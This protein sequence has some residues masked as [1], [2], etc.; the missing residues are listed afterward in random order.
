MRINKKITAALAAIALVFNCGIGCFIPQKTARAEEAQVITAQDVEE[1]Q[2]FGRA[3]FM[4]NNVSAK[5]Y[6]SLWFDKLYPENVTDRNSGREVRYTDDL[7]VLMQFTMHFGS[8]AYVR[9][10]VLGGDSLPDNSGAFKFASGSTVLFSARAGLTFSGGPMNFDPGV[11]LKV[12]DIS[13]P[14]IVW[15]ISS[16]ESNIY[17][18]G[19]EYYGDILDRIKKRTTGMTK[20]GSTAFIADNITQGQK[21]SDA[22]INTSNI[23]W[24]ASVPGTWE[25]VDG[26][27]VPEVG[28][29]K[30]DVR[31]VPENELAYETLTFTETGEITV[32]EAPA[33]GGENGGNQSGGE[34]GQNAGQTGE[35]QSGGNQSG[36]NNSG[37]ESQSGGNQPGNENQSGGTNTGG[38]TSPGNNGGNNPSASET[39]P[40]SETTPETPPDDPAVTGAAVSVVEDDGEEEEEIIQPIIIE[41]VVD[42]ITKVKT[43]TVA[44]TKITKAKRTGTKLTIKVKKI[45]GAKYQLQYTTKPK[46]WKKAKS[47]KFSSTKK[48][49]K[50]L[51]KNKKYYIRIRAY[52]K[53]KGKTVYGSWCKR[54]S[55]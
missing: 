5:Y 9:I 2:N 51:T 38:N 49:I 24:E 28:T 27:T 41:K 22:R 52:K 1:M 25:F 55:C 10:N 11:K 15:D 12:V 8:K 26:D 17:G 43:N 18:N 48:T 20:S 35:N 54:R 19:V 14:G 44:T 21:L 32:D 39:N 45:K 4:Q 23:Y 50:G 3:N 34:N 36:G 30:Y 47:V 40:G 46:T 33:S 29:H 6:M 31:F 37:N 53:I 42:T 7:T 13:V 16:C